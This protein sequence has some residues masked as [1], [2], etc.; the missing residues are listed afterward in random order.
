MSR[1]NSQIELEVTDRRL[2]RVAEIS[3]A[4]AIAEGM[5]LLPACDIPGWRHPNQY[6]AP[7]DEPVLVQGDWEY[8]ARDA[9]RNYWEQL[10]GHDAWHQNDLVWAIT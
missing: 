3:E 4:D 5:D 1:R 8:S 10:H 9:Y 2:Q 7:R 6:A